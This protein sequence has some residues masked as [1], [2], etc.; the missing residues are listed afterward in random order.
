MS[1]FF[2]T[3][4]KIN[5]IEYIKESSAKVSPDT[6]STPKIAQI[7]PEPIVSISFY[8]L[9]EFLYENKQ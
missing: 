9:N 4:K 8:K 2:F 6:Q 3:L 1:Q 5:T 7:S